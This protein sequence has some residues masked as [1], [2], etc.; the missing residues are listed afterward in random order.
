MPNTAKTISNIHT[1][2]VAVSR[3][4]INVAAVIRVPA[5]SSD[6][7]LPN[8]PSIRPDSGEKI[9]APMAIGK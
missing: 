2:V 9:N 7:R 5:T 1:G 4:S 8:R 3:V 6:G